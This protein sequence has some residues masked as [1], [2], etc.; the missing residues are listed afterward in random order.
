MSAS[1]NRRRIIQSNVMKIQQEIHDKVLAQSNVSEEM[2][3]PA[4][5]LEEDEVGSN[6][7]IFL[8]PNSKLNEVPL[9]LNS[10]LVEGDELEVDLKDRLANWAVQHNITSTAIDDLL[11][12]L[13]AHVTGSNLP[14]CA[15]GLVGTPKNYEISE[16][17]G[18]SYH[19]FGLKQKLLFLSKVFTIPRDGVLWIILGI[20]GLPI[21]KSS[22]KQFWPILGRCINVANNVPFLIGL[23]YS[24]NSKPVDVSEFLQPFVTEFKKLSQEGIRINGI[25][26]Q[27]RLQCIVADAPA[28][29]LIKQTSAFNGYNGCD[30]CIDKGVWLGRVVFKN[31]QADLRS[32]I[33]FVGQEDAN[34]HVGIS[35]LIGLGVGMVSGVV[36]D[37]MH[38]ICLGVVKKLLKCWKR[39]PM[40]KEG[41]YTIYEISDRLIQLRK[42]VC[43]EFNRKPRPLSELEF[44]KATELRNFLLYFG[45]FALKGLLSSEKYEHFMAL[46][47]ATRILLSNNRNWYN[48]ARHLMFEFTKN[49]GKL[50]HDQFLVYNVH[51]L[52]HLTDDADKFGSLEKVNAFAFENSMQ[53]LK[54]MLRGKSRHLP[55]VIRRV[56]ELE[57]SNVSNTTFRIENNLH[58]SKKINDRGC[59][60]KTG[61]VV[62]VVKKS[63][64]DFVVR[65]F[66]GQSE[67]FTKPCKGSKFMIQKVFNLAFRSTTITQS[68]IR[69]KVML[70]PISADN[71]FFCVPLCEE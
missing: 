28:R 13:S 33:G 42:F 1:R 19:H 3:Q 31:L 62:I 53:S 71:S 34:H 32:D 5:M 44:W 66:K 64:N 16:I 46:S 11:G 39:G 61:C 69:C 17:Q 56:I 59:I 40:H 10:N 24:D 57:K 68:E 51:S 8:Q 38:L 27:V 60:L 29:N 30:R 48:Y 55:Q 63:E 2:E 18:G 37:Y 58:I 47:I 67:Y 6:C 70:F 35:P 43:S 22:K 54:K 14:K 20:D 52:I 49:I 23:Y 21:S 7:Q 9:I 41:K 12:I 65:K 36:L 26:Y 25:L 50:Y 4:L 45:P 15:K